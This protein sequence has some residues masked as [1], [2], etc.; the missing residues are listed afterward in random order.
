MLFDEGAT[1]IN[2][3]NVGA[4]DGAPSTEGRLVAGVFVVALDGD[5]VL[6]LTPQDFPRDFEME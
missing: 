6:V 2:G 1:D 5:A 3:F 4:A